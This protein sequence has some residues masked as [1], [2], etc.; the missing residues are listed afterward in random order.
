MVE[1]IWTNTA[2]VDLNN[3]G[4]YIAKDSPHFTSLTIDTLFNQI[5]ACLFKMV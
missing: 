4:D 2:I 3:I 1:I 5:A